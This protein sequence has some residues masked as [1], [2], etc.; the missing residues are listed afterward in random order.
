VLANIQVYRARLGEAQA[1]RL[2]QDLKL[3]TASE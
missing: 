3:R 2:T 1:L